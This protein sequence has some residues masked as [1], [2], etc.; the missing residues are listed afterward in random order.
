MSDLPEEPITRGEAAYRRLRAD[1]VACRL[2]PGTRLT[3]EQLITETGF[4]TSP[5]RD[6][7]MRLDNEGLIRT[8]PRKGYQVSPLTPKSVDDLLDLWGIVGPEMVRRGVARVGAEQK[9]LAVASL[10]EIERVGRTAP[11][12]HTAERLVELL[13]RT[14]ALLAEASGNAYLVALIRRLSGDLARVWMV[15]LTAESTDAA[16]AAADHLVRKILVQEDPDVAAEI[17]RRYLE[18]LRDQVRAA[19]SQWPSIAN[20]QILPRGRTSLT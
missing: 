16:L 7:L 3:V 17:S 13:D 14:F 12:A 10:E 8:L 9:R 19:V 11:G 18:T 2:E 15:I 1:I 20:S 5:L 6:A 4:G